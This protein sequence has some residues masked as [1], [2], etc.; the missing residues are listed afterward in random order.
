MIG[1]MVV[2]K[3]IIKKNLLPYQNKVSNPL[4]IPQKYSGDIGVY[5][6]VCS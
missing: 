2:P 4:N 6:P 5:W 3:I 1:S